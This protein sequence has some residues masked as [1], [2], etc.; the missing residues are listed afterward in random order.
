MTNDVRPSRSA[1]M[2]CCSSSSVRVSTEEVASSRISTDGCGHERARDRDELLLARGDV[3]RVLVEHR[4]VA[5][6]QRVHEPVD[7]GGLRPASRISSSVARLTAVADVLAD[8]A[9]EQP[10]VLQHH[11]RAGAHVA[12]TQVGDV[13]AVEQDA[14]AVELVEPHDE[15][16]EGGLAGAG[17]ADDRDRLAGLAR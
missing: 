16:D 7:V 2:A 8:R 4:V 12:A 13:L 17:R 11:A 9:G 10:R 14:A 5:I 6:G 15:V 3:R 1:A